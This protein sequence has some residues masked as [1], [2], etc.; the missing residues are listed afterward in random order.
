LGFD[1]GPLFIGSNRGQPSTYPSMAGAASL[2][3]AP[4]SKLGGDAID[5]PGSVKIRSDPHG[6]LFPASRVF[7]LMF[8]FS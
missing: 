7:L 3:N 4:G 6:V 5:T 2:K 1:P 8:I